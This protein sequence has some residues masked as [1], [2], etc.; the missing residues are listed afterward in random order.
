MG[1]KNL[2][3]LN[4]SGSVLEQIGEKSLNGLDSLE[5][6]NNKSYYIVLLLTIYSF[7]TYH[8]TI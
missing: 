1:L 7:S 3:N 2:Q 8:T 6:R 4:I 5:V